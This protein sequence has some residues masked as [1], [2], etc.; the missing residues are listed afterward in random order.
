MKFMLMYMKRSNTEIPH[1]LETNATE[2]FISKTKSNN[3]KFFFI[4]G[5]RNGKCALMQHTAHDGR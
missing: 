5:A 1:I 4:A 3:F 2:L